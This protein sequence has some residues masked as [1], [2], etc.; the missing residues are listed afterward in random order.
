MPANGRMSFHLID[1]WMAFK[2]TIMICLHNE[3]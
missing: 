2:E 3:V 1:Y